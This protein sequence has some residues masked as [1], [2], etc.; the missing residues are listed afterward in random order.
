M[1]TVEAGEPKVGD[2]VFDTGSG[3]SGHITNIFRDEAG[4]IRALVLRLN[5]LVDGKSWM[6]IHVSAEGL[7]PHR[8]N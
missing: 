2:Q 6:T 8:P 7:V 3:A 4:A 5:E 1:T